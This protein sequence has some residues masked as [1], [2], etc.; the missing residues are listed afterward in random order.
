MTEMLH[1]WLAHEANR[2]PDAAAVVLDQERLSYGELETLSNQLARALK[3]RG[4]VRGDRVSLLLPN[5]P[6]AVVC[7]LGIYKADCIYVP[8]DTAAPAAQLATIVGAAGSRF[9]LAA[10]SLAPRV[11]ELLAQPG[12]PS[13]RI[14]WLGSPDLSQGILPSAFRF[15]D[16]GALPGTP[17]RGAY[18]AQDVAHIFFATGRD[19]RLQGVMGTHANVVASV[20]WALR[21]FRINETDRI[22]GHSGLAQDASLFDTFTALG[23]GAELHLVPAEAKLLPARLA[24]WIRTSD[25]TQ[26]ASASAVLNNLAEFDVVQ[27]WDF[28]ELRRVIWSGDTLPASALSYWM[29]QLPHVQ[30]TKLYGSSE[31]GFACGYHTVDTYPEQEDEELPIGVAPEGGEFLVLDHNLQP[32]QAGA[33][34]RVYARGAAVSP[35]YWQDRDS[36]AGAFPELD[37]FGRS[38]RTGDMARRGHDGHFYHAGHADFEGTPAEQAATPGKGWRA[39]DD[40][41]DDSGDIDLRRFK[42][43]WIRDGIDSAR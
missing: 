15:S 14:G 18:R 2:R 29:K 25:I 32:V 12:L 7:V 4:C 27:P 23:S 13:L 34:G 9:L 5:S 36:T 16:I 30:F 21:H 19:G 39:W 35:G 11:R 28:P 8:L 42:D 24:A 1:H 37:G 43:A 31:G 33:T 41:V 40:F 17:I 10:A 6:L 38:Y 26:W 20:D 3:E 22:A